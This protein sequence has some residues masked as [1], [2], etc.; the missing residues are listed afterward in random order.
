MIPIAVFAQQNLLAALRDHAK[1]GKEHAM[2]Q[3]CGCGRAAEQKSFQRLS[4]PILRE[5]PHHVLDQL[6]ALRLRLLPLALCRPAVC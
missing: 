3:L 1:G 2:V 4:R 6:L 5:S